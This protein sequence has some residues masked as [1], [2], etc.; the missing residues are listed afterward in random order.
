MNNIYSASDCTKGHLSL[1]RYNALY[2]LSIIVDEKAEHKTEDVVMSI[3]EKLNI[4]YNANYSSI[5][6][7]VHS[8]I[9]NNFHC[10]NIEEVYWSA[11]IEGIVS[12]LYD[13]I[14][15][16]YVSSDNKEYYYRFYENSSLIVNEQKIEENV[17][18]KN[19]ID[20]FIDDIEVLFSV[21]QN[22]NKTYVD[23]FDI[24]WSRFE[25]GDKW[26]ARDQMTHASIMLVP[27][28]PENHSDLYYQVLYDG[29]LFITKQWFI[30][31]WE[32]KEKSTPDDYILSLKSFIT[33]NQDSWAL[34]KE[35]HVVK[36]KIYTN[37]H[38]E[39]RKSFA[40]EQIILYKSL[41]D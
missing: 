15:Y 9:S 27:E 28:P 39:I 19:K 1:K 2:F 31:L 4:E 26:K 5:D 13:C 3:C 33:K 11:S 14:E 18:D 17:W 38:E 23:I 22:D 12:I 35:K 24:A 29:Y 8:Y 10:N 37:E 7:K 21:K 34:N 20:S 30:Y 25:K 40:R 6:T 16:K 41:W 36:N 32:C